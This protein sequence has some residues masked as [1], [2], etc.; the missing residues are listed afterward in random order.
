MKYDSP[1]FF[2]CSKGSPKKEVYC[3]TS[4]AQEARKVLNTQPI[5][6]TKGTRKVTA[7]KA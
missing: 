1:I 2:E 5:F 7:N 6:T 3:N 4:L